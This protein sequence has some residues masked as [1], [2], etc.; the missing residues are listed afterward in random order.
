MSYIFWYYKM[1][2]GVNSKNSR[3]L[4]LK[5]KLYGFKILDKLLRD[6]KLNVDKLDLL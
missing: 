1:F 4:I 6:H 5:I 2:K 3:F